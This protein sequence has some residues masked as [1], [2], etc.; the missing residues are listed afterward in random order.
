MGMHIV[1]GILVLVF[2]AVNFPAGSCF[3]LLLAAAAA[4]KTS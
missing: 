2:V 1:F 4:I 3:D